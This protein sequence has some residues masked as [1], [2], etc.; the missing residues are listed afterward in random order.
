MTDKQDPTPPAIRARMWTHDDETVQGIGIT[1]VVYPVAFAEDAEHARKLVDRHNADVLAAYE[2]GMREAIEALSG[3]KARE[4]LAPGHREPVAVSREEPCCA[5]CAKEN[6]R[7]RGC[8]FTTELPCSRCGKPTQGRIIQ[9]NRREEPS[10]E[11]LGRVHASGVDAHFE[12]FGPSGS[13]VAG[14][15][16]VFAAGRNFERSI[17][18][19][20]ELESI[21]IAIMRRCNEMPECPFCGIDDGE[22]EPGELCSRLDFALNGATQERKMP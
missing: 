10:D 19:A 5:A 21:A 9:M 8:A 13:S 3:K 7:V 22:H 18:S 17:C 6:E 15:R 16:A 11:E 12:K 20:C 1:S 4:P 2:A 14:H